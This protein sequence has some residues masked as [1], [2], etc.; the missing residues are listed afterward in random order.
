MTD[1]VQ[2]AMTRQV[3]SVWIDQGPLT[4][5]GGAAAR[6]FDNWLASIRESALRDAAL[7]GR[8]GTNAQSTL[9]AMAES[10][11]VA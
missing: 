7:S 11:K 9:L 6:S 5:N 2:R 10:E 1:G 8:F 4:M 3:R